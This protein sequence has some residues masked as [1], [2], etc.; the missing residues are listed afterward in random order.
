M[1]RIFVSA[2]QISDGAVVFTQEQARHLAGALRVRTGERV[3]VV[4]DGR[5]Q[6]TVRITEEAQSR[7]RGQIEDTQPATGE[8]SLQVD[9]LQAIPARGMDEAVE[10]LALTGAARIWPVITARTVA[11][12]EARRAQQR[13]ERWRVIAREAAQLAG[14][15][16]APAVQEVQTLQQAVAAI[17]GRCRILVCVLTAT[18]PMMDMRV[19][20]DVRVAML[21]GPEGGLDA[22][23]LAELDA[24][25]AERV[26]LGPRV[27]PSRLAGA[28]ALTQLF[29]ASGELRVPADS[30][31][32]A[33]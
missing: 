3:V 8:P 5:L 28:L 30:D 9:V 23:D 16:S 32:D 21:L 27:M 29:A 22:A 18:T 15:A 1:P 31:L 24:R 14:R 11:R 7:L 6:H 20:A 4:E 33:R 2:D 26:H 25:N 19:E 12:P 13:I 10:A 17:D